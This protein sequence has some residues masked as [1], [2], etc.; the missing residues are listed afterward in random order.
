M[1]SR[2]AARSAA[3]RVYVPSSPPRDHPDDVRVRLGDCTRSLLRPR[4]HGRGQTGGGN[5]QEGAAVHC[6]LRFGLRG[7]RHL[8][9]ASSGAAAG[10]PRERA[11][12][13]L[14]RLG[15]VREAGAVHVEQRQHVGIVGLPR[16]DVRGGRR[17]VEGRR[18]F[19]QGACPGDVAPHHG[20]VAHAH[21][22]REQGRV[23]AG[24]GRQHERR[25]GGG[26]TRLG[27]DEWRSGSCG[28]LFTRDRSARPGGLRDREGDGGG[29]GGLARRRH[30]G[31]LLR[32]ARWGSGVGQRST[33]QRN[34]EH[35]NR[36][37]HR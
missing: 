8:R 21:Q 4:H 35:R 27:G 36:A 37:R 9:D 28:G 10:S 24:G 26:R 17:R 7:T 15:G 31:D 13:P 22:G 33:H 29:H 19:V 1:S 14:P 18:T 25:E 23:G 5:G 12:V 11:L 34:E 20:D 30:A 32:R 6:L 2:T 16:R 3:K